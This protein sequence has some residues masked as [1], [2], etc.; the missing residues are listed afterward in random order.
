MTNGGVGEYRA[1]A[2]VKPAAGTAKSSGGTA[3]SLE[4]AHLRNAPPREDL[5]GN[6]APEP[7]VPI[8]RPLNTAGGA[9]ARPDAAATHPSMVREIGDRPDAGSGRLVRLRLAGRESGINRLGY[10]YLPPQYFEPAYADVRFPVLELLH[11]DPGDPTNWIYGLRMPEV[12][13]GEIHAGR[14]GPMVIVMPAT[15]SGKHGD[16]CVNAVHGEQD[17][18]Y[19]SSDVPA[20]VVADFRVL[21]PGPSWGIG[22]LSDGGFCAANLALR[23][24][25]S[26]GAVASMDGF[27]TADADL[28]VLGA[29]FGDNAILLTENDP[30][31][32]VATSGQSL[33][34]FWIMSGT[35]SGADFEAAQAFQAVVQSREPVRDV[36]LIDGRHTP[37]AWRAV[38]PNLLEWTWTALSGQPVPAGTLTTTLSPQPS[39]DLSPVVARSQSSTCSACSSGGKIG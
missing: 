3:T 10:V 36:V 33:P 21:P 23:H 28:G 1:A 13:N 2:M 25:S 17:D 6:S 37:P 22:G 11:G 35:G 15:F 20:D 30:T 19:L 12:M 5:L 39:R 24:R 4:S 34:H 7:D 31:D 14:V 8:T 38:L 18:S 27:Y 16:D 9:L 32:E 29:D 26:Y